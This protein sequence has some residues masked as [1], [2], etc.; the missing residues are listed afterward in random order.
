MKNTILENEQ[1]EKE[2]EFEN[3]TAEANVGW[4]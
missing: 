2:G 4:D 1:G 3:I